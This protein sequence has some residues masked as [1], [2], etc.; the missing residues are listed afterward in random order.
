MGAEMPSALFPTHKRVDLSFERGEGAYL[1]GSDGQKYLDFFSGIAVTGLGHAHPHLVATACRYAD[2]VWH[3]SNNFRIPEQE[4]LAER[5]AAHSF[6]DNVYFCSTGLEAAEGAIKMA[7][8]A[9]YT[10]GSPDKVNIITVQGAFHGR[11]LAGLAATNNAQYLEGFGPRTPGFSQVPFNDLKALEAALGADTAAVM[12]EPIQGEGGIRRTP[13][14]YLRAVRALCDRTGTL[15][16]FDEVQCGMGRS[17]RLFAYEWSNI[18]PDIMMLAKGLGGGF[19]IGAIL[20]TKEISAC[21]VP[22]THGSTFGGNPFAMAIANAVLD[23][24]IEPSFLAHV[25]DMSTLLRAGLA[26]LVQ[27]YG[28]VFSEVRGVGLLVGLKCCIPNNQCVAAAREMGL[29]THVAGDNVLR[30]M[31]P[32]I[33]EPTHISEALEML[34]AVAMRVSEETASA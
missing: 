25:R 34:D 28:H 10:A 5:L 29:L 26:N 2:R 21:M 19:V 23:I 1:F 30:L 14:D 33:V 9:Q 24:M 8:R 3:I 27:K 12:L 22:G 4:R 18:A 16:I 20:A 11:S 7:R 15:L 13:L 17:G 32:L 6:A 31:P